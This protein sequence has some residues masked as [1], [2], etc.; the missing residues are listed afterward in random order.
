MASYLKINCSDC[1][2]SYSKYTSKGVENNQQAMEVNIRSVYAM[3]KCGVGH[4]GLQK[5]CGVM[6]MPPPVAQKSY[7]KLSQK[8][9]VAV[10]K[11]AKTSMIEAAV[12]FIV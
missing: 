12:S 9:G 4:T 8:L 3:R 7:D 2:F 6:N 5:F 11:V 10:E 1:P